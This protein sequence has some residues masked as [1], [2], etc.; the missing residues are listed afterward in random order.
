METRS[1]I[2]NR[3][4]LPD[5]NHREE[6]SPRVPLIQVRELRTYFPTGRRG[7]FGARGSVKAVDGLT[8]DIFKGETLG[9]VGESGCGKSTTGRAI[10]RLIRPTAGQVFY[11][12]RDLTKVSDREMR[13]MRQRLQ[14]IFQDAYASVS[15]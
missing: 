5:G 6:R 2:A 11:D 8:F 3:E 9:L 14:I 7:L 13:R 15:S 1:G 4:A 10:I 12:G